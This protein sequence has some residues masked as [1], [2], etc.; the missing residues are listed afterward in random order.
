MKRIYL[1]LIV[2]FL[3]GGLFTTIVQASTNDTPVDAR[4]IQEQKVEESAFSILP[5]KPNYLLPFYYTFDPYREIYEGSTPDDQNIKKTEIKF[6]FSFKVPVWQKMFG[7]PVSLYVA[8][9]QL[10]YWQAYQQ[11]PFFRETNYEPEIFAS[12]KIDKN[13]LGNWQ[14]NFVNLGAVH[15]SN[16]RGGDLERSWNRV[17]LVFITSL[18]NWMFELK[19]WFAIRDSSFREHNPDIL[20]YLGHGKMI[21]AYK[22]HNNNTLALETR[23]NLESGF[24]RGALQFTWSFPLIKKIKGYVQIFSG[25]GQSLIEYDHYTNSIGIGFALNDYV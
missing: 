20:R 9:T 25:Y 3:L 23:N 2:I 16:G 18:N 15:Q 10:S 6:Q 14:L 13:I 4:V 17:Y 1:F 19:S 5:Y 7:K 12:Y 8:Y 22:F 21:I 24:S 11:S